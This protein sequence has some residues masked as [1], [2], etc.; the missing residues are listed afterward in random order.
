MLSKRVRTAIKIGGEAGQC[1]YCIYVI[2]DKADDIL[3]SF[4]FTD[5]E[6]KVYRTVQEKFDNYVLRATTQ[7]YFPACQV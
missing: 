1:T 2:G 3:N 6:R 5:D 7:C 4:G